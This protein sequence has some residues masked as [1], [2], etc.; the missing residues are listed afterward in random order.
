MNSGVSKLIGQAVCRHKLL[1]DNSFN[2]TLIGMTS[3]DILADSTRQYIQDE[4]E[5]I[6]ML[7]HLY[8]RVCC[9]F[10]KGRASKPDAERWLQ[11]KCSFPFD[12]DQAKVPDVHHTHL[13]LLD[14]NRPKYYLDDE[15]RS[16]FVEVVCKE[17]K[18]HA[19]T[20]IVEGG[21]FTPDVILKDVQAGRP[22]VIIHGSG[23]IASLLGMLLEPTDDK[24]E[25]K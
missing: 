3:W 13:I 24:T 10:L 18:C 16:R 23:R 4:V 9:L 1:H 20:I 6:T 15:P 8:L 11:N 17:S 22:V 19:V 25:D 5:N 2:P 14:I 12:D 7:F 21:R